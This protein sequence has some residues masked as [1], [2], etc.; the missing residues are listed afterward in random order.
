MFHGDLTHSGSSN[1]AAPT[2]NATLWKFNTGGQ[3]DSPTV[4]GGVVY[5]GSFD[6]KI[7]AFN[8][9]D[10]TTIWSYK[11]GGVVISR[12][13]VVNGVVY[14]GSEDHNLYA[15]NAATG[16]KLWNYTTGYYVDC[17][18]AVANGIVYFGSEDHNVY[19][20]KRCYRN[21]HMELHNWQQNYVVL[22]SGEQRNSLHR[23][24]R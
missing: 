17:D 14:V 12:P 22:T 23:I 1:S 15:L 5:V 9:S 19:A 7:Y 11:T 2:T 21:I 6:H 18:P 24:R 13:A 20:L 3:V 4:V 8:A 10:G 16:A